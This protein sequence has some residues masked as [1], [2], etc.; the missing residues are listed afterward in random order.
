MSLNGI[1]IFAEEAYVS[2]D[3]ISGKVVVSVPR[4]NTAGDGD[5][6][7]VPK[8][9]RRI[10]KKPRRRP[11]GDLVNRKF[12]TGKA[13]IADIRKF[14]TK[15]KNGNLLTPDES[16]EV[17]E[18]EGYRYGSMIQLKKD[19]ILNLFLKIRDRMLVKDNPFDPVDTQE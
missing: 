6:R 2:P 15:W 17:A 4:G 14:F 8:K 12:D 5:G 18:Q 9:R 1:E 19:E 7:E 11:R 10:L 16:V 13:D 3:E